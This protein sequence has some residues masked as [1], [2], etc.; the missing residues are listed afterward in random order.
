MHR[1][2]RVT[3]CD[4]GRD[5]TKGTHSGIDNVYYTYTYIYIYV[6]SKFYGYT[7]IFIR[8][9]VNVCAYKSM[10]HGISAGTL[11][12]KKTYSGI[13]TMCHRF[14]S[15]FAKEPLIIYMLH[16]YKKTYSGI[17]TM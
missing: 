3:G 12:H 5:V 9:A 10:S 13:H 7:F 14:R 11:C 2:V 6:S 4:R 15:F 16:I 1:D 8:I 17:H